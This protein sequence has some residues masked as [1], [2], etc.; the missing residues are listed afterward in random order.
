MIK[1]CKNII[2]IGIECDIYQLSDRFVYKHY[3]KYKP[4]PATNNPAKFLSKIDCNYIEKAYDYDD[5][6]FVTDYLP[7]S[8]GT[9]IC[10]EQTKLISINQIDILE[11]YLKSTNLSHN[12]IF[13]CNIMYKNGNPILIDWSHLNIPW[14][15]YEPDHIGFSNWRRVVKTNSNWWSNRGFSLLKTEF[16]NCMLFYM[17]DEL[18]LPHNKMH[19]SSVALHYFKKRN[20]KVFHLIDRLHLETHLSDAVKFFFYTKDYWI[21][22]LNR[23]KRNTK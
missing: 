16:M 12:D 5:E 20:N 15:D 6:G 23:V 4:L 8:A 2:N 21:E 19:A 13:P 17:K 7:L 18:K 14:G 9:L 22:N 11:S 3:P 10:Y 1:A